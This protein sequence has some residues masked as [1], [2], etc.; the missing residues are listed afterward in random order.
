MEWI[1]KILGILTIVFVGVMLGKKSVE[2]LKKKVLILSEIIE[3]LTSVKNN[4]MY[5]HNDLITAF[6]EADLTQRRYFDIS[7]KNLDSTLFKEE[8]TTRLNGC[9]HIKLLL[10]ETQ[11]EK[12][13]D[14][15]L[16][17]GI[18][19]LAEECGKLGYYINYFEQERES[20]KTYYKEN[21]RLFYA[22]SLYASIV[23]AVILI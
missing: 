16:G 12:L 10:S 11:K 6:N 9:I 20:A 4:F 1:T 19:S 2:H 15:M 5:R 23:L 22:I 18:G 7:L 13:Y 14:S 3:V 21:Q 8:L 17:I